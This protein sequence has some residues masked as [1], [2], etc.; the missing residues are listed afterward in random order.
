MELHGNC[1]AYKKRGF[2]LLAPHST[3]KSQLTLLLTRMYQCKLV[4]D[5]CTILRKDDN[6]IICNPVAGFSGKIECQPFGIIS[7]ASITNVPLCA[8]FQHQHG[9]EP[10]QHDPQK[11]DILGLSFPL[12][13]IDFQSPFAVNIIGLI[14]KEL[15]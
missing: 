2:I 3:G 7:I 12:Y 6:N 14:I 13:Y 11:M 1:I 15:A 4:A 9:A 10:Y 5:D 8:I